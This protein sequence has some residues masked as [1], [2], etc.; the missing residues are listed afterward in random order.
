MILGQ[1]LGKG[2]LQRQHPLHIISCDDHKQFVLRKYW[3]LNKLHLKRQKEAKQQTEFARSTYSNTISSTLHL[4]LRLKFTLTKTPIKLHRASIHHGQKSSAEPSHHMSLNTSR[5]KQSLIEAVVSI[6]L[7]EN[8][9]IIPNTSS[10]Y[11]KAPNGA[12][13]DKN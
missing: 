7:D 4:K 10:T 13:L 1:G 6:V 2:S 5:Q 8:R 11:I 3:Q 9:K 12:S